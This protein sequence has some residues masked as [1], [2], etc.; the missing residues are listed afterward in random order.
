MKKGATLISIFNAIPLSEAGNP[1]YMSW[2]RS[3]SELFIKQGLGAVARVG[4]GSMLLNALHSQGG[5]AIGISP[6]ASY[7]EHIQAFRLPEASFPIIYSGRGGLGADVSA[8]E[9]SSGVLILGDDEEALLGILGCIDTH[10]IPV[11]ILMKG[12]Q[13][14]VRE[15]VV[16]RYPRLV[17]FL[18]LG[19]DPVT[20]MGRFSDEV[21]KQ[22]NSR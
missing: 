5:L 1:S 14:L 19:D 18:V 22:K 4:A 12:E 16:E 15:K 10:G 6:A 3:L 20:L 8:L 13:T 11:A 2:G 21:R 17:P 7:R 9:S